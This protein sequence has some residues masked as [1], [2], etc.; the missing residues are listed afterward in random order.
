MSD[1]SF[2]VTPP[3]VHTVEHLQIAHVPT[4][5]V[6]AYLNEEHEDEMQD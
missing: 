4:Y 6:P 1:N 3:N 5:F 2:S